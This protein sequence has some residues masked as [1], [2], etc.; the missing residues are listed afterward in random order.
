MEKIN[1]IRSLIL[2][3]II[4][5]VIIAGLL[6]FN[7]LKIREKQ[8]RNDAIQACAAAAVSAQP[9]GGFNGAVYKICVEDKGYETGIK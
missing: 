2:V 5:A 1:E 6:G 8:V 7:F 4:T 3:A 9:E